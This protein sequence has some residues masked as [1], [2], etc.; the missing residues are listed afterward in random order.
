MQNTAVTIFLLTASV[1]IVVKKYLIQNI[2]SS[3]SIKEQ[4]RDILSIYK[5]V[6][7]FIKYKHKEK[8]TLSL[9]EWLRQKQED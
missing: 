2:D 5:K 8:G 1:I 4:I 7:S 6:F 3:F 9:G